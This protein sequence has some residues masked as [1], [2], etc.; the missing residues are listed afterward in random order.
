MATTTSERVRRTPLGA[1]VFALALAAAQS[2]GADTNVGPV[3]ITGDV[4]FGGRIVWGDENEAKFFEY[5][6]LRDGLFGG[7]DVLVENPDVTHWLR[8]RSH[9]PGYD[10][11]RYRLE[12]GRYG[13]YELDL[14]YGELPHVFSTRSMTPY[15][16]A[17]DETLVLALTPAE[18]A[19]IEAAGTIAPGD[20]PLMPYGLGL[21]WREGRIG[22]QYHAGESL[23][24]RASYRIQDKQGQR[25]AGMN[26]GTPGG[27]FISVP[28]PIDERIHEVTAGADWT[29]GN[30]VFSLE[31]VGN[32]F[33]NDL[34]SLTADNPL[35]AMDAVD[36]SASMDDAFAG[37]GRRATYPDNSSHSVS[38][39]GATMLP[40]E[41]P[42]R[43]SASFVYGYRQ[44]DQDFLPHTNNT[45]LPTLPLAMLA[46]PQNSLDGSVQ[47]LLGNV[48]ATIQPLPELGAKFRYRIYDYDNQTDSITFPQWVLND[49]TIE[50]GERTS[51]HNDYRRQQANLDLSWDFAKN[52]TSTFG[53]G[54]DYWHRSS[55]REVEDLHEHGPSLKVDYRALDGLLLHAGYQFRTRDGSSYNS[56]AP[57]LASTDLT[58]PVDLSAAKFSLVRKFDEADRNMH[59]FDL[60]GKLVP[61]ED[62]EL[63]FTGNVAC[64]DYDDS[65]YGLIKS[66]DWSAGSDVFYQVHPRVGLL[67]YYTYEWRK[68]TQNSR[69]RPRTFAPPI[70]ITD[71]PANDWRSRTRYQYHNAGVDLILALIPEKLDA[72][73][74]YLVQY[75]QEKTKVQNAPGGSGSGD[76]VDWPSVNDLLQSVSGSLAWH[77]TDRVTFGVGYRYEDYSIDN[78]RDDNIPVTLTDG[79]NVFLGDVVGDYHAHI[80]EMAAT[81]RF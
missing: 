19:A 67:G 5:R 14:F 21:R 42:N 26:F 16:R 61:V 57:I 40:I 8:A 17:S 31:Y 10:D 75:G 25:N 36:P 39:S 64:V 22:A 58:D 71:D 34:D 6:D 38:L 60:L 56:F 3:R 77:F 7:F 47:T 79:S 51:V 76:A 12:G 2:A 70:V 52:W 78:F 55:D 15:L 18:R 65:S 48:V 30:S 49:E 23:V 28:A 4:E 32:I 74:G 1:A 68:S 13:R 59:R 27:D 66:L 20:L 37:S 50:T 80:V 41:M 81:L 62:L 35:H 24:L 11:Q 33:D 46:L 69:Y 9:N 54:W 73:L 45:I 43:I 72:D 44:Q 29:L 63:T 53:Y